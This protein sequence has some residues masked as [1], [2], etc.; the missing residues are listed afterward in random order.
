MWKKMNL[1]NKLTMIRIILVPLFVL[2][3]ALPKTI[4]WNLWVAL[5]IFIVA[6][7]TDFIDGKIA[8]S[9]NLITKFGKIMDPLADKMLVSAGFIMLS[10]YG[11]IPGWM[12]A[13]IILRDFFV[14]AL[15]MFGAD[16]NE[17]LSASVSGKVKTACELV[18]IPLAII[19]MALGATNVYGAF[20][21]NSISMTVF[22]LIINIFMTVFV[23]LAVLATVWSLVDYIVRFKDSVNVEE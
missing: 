23:S 8:R 12:S 2:F 7:L 1:P 6:A 10:Y 15:R 16:R 14:N 13:I 19:S 3:M 4:V 9:K 5:G 11:I 20:I 18:S 21:A 22:S 17:D